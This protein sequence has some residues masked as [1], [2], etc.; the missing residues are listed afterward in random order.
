MTE[1]NITLETNEV[2][3]EFNWMRPIVI[4]VTKDTVNAIINSSPIKQ[5]EKNDIK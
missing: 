3:N 5:E 4:T 2:E 1:Q